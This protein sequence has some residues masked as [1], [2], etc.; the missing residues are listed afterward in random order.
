M[1]NPPKW[2]TVVGVGGDVRQG[3]LA[4]KPMPALYV[5]LL[6]QPSAS[7]FLVLHTEGHVTRSDIARAIETADPAEPVASEHAVE[8]LLSRS[9][10]EPRFRAETLGIFAVLAMLI[11]AMGIYGVM[12]FSVSRRTHEIGVSMA[13]GAEKSDVLRM[14]VGQG[15]RQALIGVAIGIAGALALTRF[16]ASLLYGVKPTDP[17]TYIAVALVACYIP[18]RRAAKVDPMVALRYE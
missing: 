11:A 8:Q 4:E 13:L 2:M 12:A 18:A 1:G 9:T 16:L 3:G 15:L 5:P 7:A 17:P 10:A 6:Q 14:V